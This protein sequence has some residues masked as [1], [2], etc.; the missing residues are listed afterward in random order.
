MLGHSLATLPLLYRH[1]GLKQS[2]KVAA[3][4]MVSRLFAFAWTKTSGLPFG[5]MFVMDRMAR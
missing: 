4:D 1:A 2:S 3:F 5:T